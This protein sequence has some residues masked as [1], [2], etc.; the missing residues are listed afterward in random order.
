[1]W[2]FAPTTDKRMW[3]LSAN[4]G[5]RPRAGLRLAGIRAQPATAAANHGRLGEF[6]GNAQQRVGGAVH[7]LGRHLENPPSLGPC[8]GP[9]QLERLPGPEPV[10]FREHPDGLLHP[11]PGGQRVLQ[12]GD[13]LLELA[14]ISGRSLA[15]KA[16]GRAATVGMA[17]VGRSAASRSA[18][19]MALVRSETSSS[20][21]RQPVAVRR[22]TG[23]CSAG[24][25]SPRAGPCWPGG[26]PP[27][28]P[29]WPRPGSS[30][31]GP[32]PA[33][34]LWAWPSAAWA[35]CLPAFVSC[36]PGNSCP[37]R[38]R[39]AGRQ[40]SWISGHVRAGQDPPCLPYCFS[41]S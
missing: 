27:G 32:G 12:L 24:E 17:C 22:A 5:R 26:R 41:L 20:P 4:D 1:M 2:A 21:T 38:C 13:G 23:A 31:T 34:A 9:E 28:T 25:P 14:W 39:P 36:H 19:T 37:A 40:P 16:G 11:D 29:R 35:A 8:H 7:D 3:A 10:P 18:R 33:P 30:V 6:L 15:V